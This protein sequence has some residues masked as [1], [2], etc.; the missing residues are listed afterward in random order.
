MQFGFD[1]TWNF[2]MVFSVNL[3]TLQIAHGF[4]NRARAIFGNDKVC[5]IPL[6]NEHPSMVYGAHSYYYYYYY[7]YYR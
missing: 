5:H 6:P 2:E 7:C 1:N 3:A 4:C